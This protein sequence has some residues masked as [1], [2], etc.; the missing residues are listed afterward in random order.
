MMPS[1]SAR[2]K[3]VWLDTAV[4]ASL[5]DMV[6]YQKSMAQ[7]HEFAE[8]LESLQWPG[9]DD[10]YD[11]V[12][13]SAKIWLVKRRE[14]SLDWTRNQLALGKH[15]LSSFVISSEIYAPFAT[16]RVVTHNDD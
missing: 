11:W 6:E 7:V 8:K 10:F 9:I 5:D 16:W 3:E 14:T 4:P 13:N 12:T 2:I 15:E 1:L